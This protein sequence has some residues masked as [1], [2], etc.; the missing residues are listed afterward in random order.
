MA[1]K[2]CK[3]CGE[4]ISSSAKK[5]PKC[6]KDQRNFFMKH[7]I[8]YTIIILIVI[9]IFVGMDN[10]SN[11]TTNSTNTYKKN[12]AVEVTI[13]DFSSM[14]KD[15]I[16]VWFDNNKINGKFSEE[17]SNEIEKGSFISQSVA[18]NTV[19]HEGDSIT[20]TYSLGK[21]PTNEEKNALIKA[22]TY[23]ETMHM[24]KEG[25][26]DQLTSE[27]GENFSKEAAQ[28]A[29]DNMKADWNANALAK[30]KTYQE[31]MNMSKNA[32]Y[33]QLVSS[34]GEKFTK[35]EAQY[36]IDHLDD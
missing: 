21:K 7:P 9:C 13:V 29:I 31:T 36:A 34:Y 15:E 30:A 3:E 12:T 11:N 10:D 8:L 27:Y 25:I 20:V 19:A 6:G 28:Y 26:Y 1:M 4:E 23:S 2:K 16:Q 18:A 24:S 14:T 33:D 5:C 35:E 17:Y 32:I 22:E